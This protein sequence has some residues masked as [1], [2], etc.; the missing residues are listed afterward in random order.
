MRASEFSQRALHSEPGFDT[1]ILQRTLHPQ[2]GFNSDS[3]MSS[4]PTALLS[5][6][7]AW[8]PRLQCDDDF[9]FRASRVHMGDDCLGCWW[10]PFI[11]RGSLQIPQRSRKSSAFQPSRHDKNNPRIW[12]VWKGAVLKMTM[13]YTK[14]SIYHRKKEEVRAQS[15]PK[16]R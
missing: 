9:I 11:P 3:P 7:A 2:S 15:P 13:R 6:G 14:P 4:T 16:Y 8:S 12:K 10:H 5:Q 1:V